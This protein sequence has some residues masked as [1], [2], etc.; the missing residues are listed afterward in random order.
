MRSLWEAQAT[1]FEGLTQ[2]PVPDG[3]RAVIPLVVE[4]DDNCGWSF[5][6]LNV[7][8]LTRDGEPRTESDEARHGPGLVAEVGAI[9]AVVGLSRLMACSPSTEL[10]IMY[11]DVEA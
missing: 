2:A 4:D 5:W 11:V 10:D 7:D 8:E 1:L 3:R 9:L 6:S